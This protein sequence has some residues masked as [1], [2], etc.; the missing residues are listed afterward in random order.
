MLKQNNQII[1][2][3]QKII[4][5][6]ANQKIQLKTRVIGFKNNYEDQLKNQSN[7]YRICTKSKNPTKK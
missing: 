7:E 6:L 1:L 5:K 2:K 4:L 3:K